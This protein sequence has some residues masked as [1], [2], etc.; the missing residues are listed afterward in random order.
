MNVQMKRAARPRATRDD[1]AHTAKNNATR[2][3]PQRLRQPPYGRKLLALRARG[4]APTLAVL[5]LDGWRPALIEDEH[6][7]WV[8]VIPDGEAASCSD[9]RCVAG[10][11]V[12][13][14]ADR[15]ARA[16]EIAIPVF[17]RSTNALRV[18][19]RARVVGF[20]RARGA[21]SST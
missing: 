14:I 9:F 16:D 17:R 3:G 6:A 5:I 11:F 18:D 19:G 1:T 15:I 7:P 4:Y 20:L 21:M 8:L 10:L 2:H 13:I 12:Y